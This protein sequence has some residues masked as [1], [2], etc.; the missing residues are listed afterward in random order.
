M[1]SK[2]LFA[3]AVLLIVGYV[4]LR[5]FSSSPSSDT[6]PPNVVV[7]L[8]DTLRPDY[9]GVYGHEP[10]TAPFISRIA[11]RSTVFTRAFSTSSWTAPSTASLFTSTYPTRHGVIVGFRAHQQRE[12]N[13]RKAGGRATVEVNRIPDDLRTLPELFQ[14]AGYATF[15]LTSNRN[16]GDEEGFTRGFDLFYKAYRLPAEVIYDEIE[17][18]KEEMEDSRPYFLYIHLND[19][20]TPYLEREPY[21]RRLAGH[22]S[23]NQRRYLSEIGYVDAHIKKIYNLLNMDRNTLLMVLSDHGEEF[24]DHG[25]IGHG[26]HLYRELNQVLMLV[27]SRALGIPSQRINLNVSLIDVIPTL[28]E[29]C[30]LQRIPQSQG[31]SLA[32]LLC[33]DPGREDLRGRLEARTLFAHRIG[34]FEPEQQHWAATFQ[35]WKFYDPWDDR[36]QLFDH[37]VDLAEKRNVIE[38]HSDLASTLMEQLEVFKKTADESTAKTVAVPLDDEL[39]ETLQSLGYVE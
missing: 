5:A 4:L 26:P 3:G 23:G 36:P 30:G 38:E 17:R 14:E 33:D 16:I 15:G 28:I 25:G 10:E 20:H 34:G 11:R 18:W 29:L 37:R 7:V 19:V 35:H 22:A 31:T 12:M 8:I 1:R 13:F 21:Y 6:L 2:A 39:F 24:A 9:L 32:P 27:H